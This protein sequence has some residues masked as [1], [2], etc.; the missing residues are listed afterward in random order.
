MPAHN[1][2]ASIPHRRV[3]MT[4]HQA[5][6]L[7]LQA[8]DA[9]GKSPRT[10]LSYRQ[11]LRI[12]HE[13]LQLH[14][15]GD[16]WFHPEVI[17]HF[18]AAERARGM[19]PN[20]LAGRWRALVVFFNWLRRRGFLPSTVKLP[21]EEMEAPKGEQPLIEHVHLDEFRRLYQSI[22]GDHWSDW[23]DRTLL[24]LLFWS[25]LRVS[26]T[27]G[28][29]VSDIDAALHL[30]K[31][32]HGKGGKGRIVPCTPDI[33]TVLLQ[34]IYSRPFWS[35]AQLFLS[36]DGNGGVRGALTVYGVRMVLKRLCATAHV[37]YMHPHLFR[38]GFAM[39]FLNAG[40]DMSA[41]S[42]VLGHSSEKI[43]EKIYAHWLTEG[44]SREYEE[45]R[46][47]LGKQKPQSK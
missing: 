38:H 42:K 18:L 31:I 3:F 28:L 41:V 30:V 43:T 23:R 6:E 19:K 5:I 33:F 25:G 7:F 13:W 32:R 14:Y 35:G 17:D 16:S 40:M 45:I 34:Y 29:E 20:T 1:G 26:E 22:D 2:R 27:V 9:T 46:S 44:L 39:E 11:H 21:T 37:R 36:N 12:F 8:K 4:L 47:K 10:I 15:A 24:L